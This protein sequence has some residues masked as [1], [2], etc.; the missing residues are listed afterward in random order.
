MLS[1]AMDTAPAMVVMD[2]IKVTATAGPATHTVDMEDTTSVTPM[3]SQAMDTMSA[4]VVMDM[5]MVTAIAGPA[6]PTMDT[7]TTSVILSQAME[8]MVTEATP[9]CTDLLRDLVHRKDTDPMDMDTTKLNLTNI[10]IFMLTL[11]HYEVFIQ[12]NP[13][14][15]IENFLQ[16]LLIQTT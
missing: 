15:N 2:I 9:T 3:L 8:D 7:A 6:T 10:L 4:M 12:T 16:V 1:Q 5:D 11:L 14:E 13:K